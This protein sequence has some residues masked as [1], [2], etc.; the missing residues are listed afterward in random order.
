NA[1][2]MCGEFWVG[3]FD[4]WGERRQT[5]SAEKAAEGLDWMLARGISVNL[6]MFHGGTT[7]GFMNGANKYEAY[8]P[9][10]SSYDYDSPLDEAGRPTEKF[11]ALREVIKKRLP[12]GTALPE[13][14][15][16]LPMVEIPRFE[17]RESANLLSALGRPVR[18]ARPQSM[19]AVGQ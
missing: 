19:E 2:R 10:I 12:A 1:P 13:L 18:A 15:A 5:V 9:D 17:L 4:A 6:Y 8:Q 3:W 16:P 14:P 7:F 11:F